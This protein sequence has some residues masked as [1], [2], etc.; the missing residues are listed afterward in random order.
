MQAQPDLHPTANAGFSAG[1]LTYTRGRPDYPEALLGWLRDELQLG[2]GRT[3]VELGAGT[4]KFTALLARTGAR[5]LAVEPVAAMRAQFRAPSPDPPSPDPLAV[6]PVS[7]APVPMVAPVSPVNMAA[8][9]AEAIPVRSGSAD[10]VVCAQAF[11]WFA[12]PT[13]LREIHR[14]L[15]PGGQLGLVWNVRDES[16]EWIAAITAILAPYEAD[17][18]RFASERWREVFARTGSRELFS[19]LRPATWRYEAVGP[20][21]RVIV[22]R[23]LSVSFIAALPAEE[24]ASVRQR[25]RD[26]IDSHPQLRDRAQIAFPYVT[27]AYQCTRI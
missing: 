10:A 9:L 4:G 26:L 16:V 1:A 8:G 2:A 3:A 24:Q 13:A 20:P 23:F 6:P 12:T 7:L 21:Q 18:P 19:E 25:L 15:R 27:H 22:E 17:A 14:A 5:V 11:H